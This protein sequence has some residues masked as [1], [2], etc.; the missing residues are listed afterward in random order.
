MFHMHTTQYKHRTRNNT[1]SATVVSTKMSGTAHIRRVG[2]IDGSGRG[3]G[4]W[5]FDRGSRMNYAVVRHEEL[6]NVARHLD[7]DNKRNEIQWS[8]SQTLTHRKHNG[9]INM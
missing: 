7:S 9:V 6:E 3:G 2:S 4:D 8:T 1:D 5:Q